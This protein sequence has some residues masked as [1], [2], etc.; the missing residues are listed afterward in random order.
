M[1]GTLQRPR[2]WQQADLLAWRSLYG[3]N[4]AVGSK[5]NGT[6]LKKPHGD[7]KGMDVVRPLA[8][9]PLQAHL[10]CGEKRGEQAIHTAAKANSGGKRKSNPRREAKNKQLKHPMAGAR[11]V[12]VSFGSLKPRAPFRRLPQ[13]PACLWRLELS[14]FSSRRHAYFLALSLKPRLL[15]GALP[16][17]T[18]T[19]R[20]A[21]YAFL[22]W[23][24]LSL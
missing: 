16:E 23:G 19:S 7:S 15:L 2:L 13:L 22:P 5:D 14:T 9:L 20:R 8:N 17:A 1:E 3:G 6:G 4:R 21:L 10:I 11:V 18:P 12:A 24:P